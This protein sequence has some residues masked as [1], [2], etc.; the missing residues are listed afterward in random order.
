MEKEGPVGPLDKKKDSGKE[1]R[2]G[3]QKKESNWKHAQLTI[4]TFSS[5]LKK[6]GKKEKRKQMI[7]RSPTVLASK[8]HIS[9]SRLEESQKER[10]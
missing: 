9:G 10:S 1:N 8:E 4:L 7:S 5:C 6:G 2:S 3:S